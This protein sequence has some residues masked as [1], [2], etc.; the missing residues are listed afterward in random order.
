MLA[1]GCAPGTGPVEPPAHAPAET[2]KTGTGS[3]IQDQGAPPPE[4]VPAWP[5]QVRKTERGFPVNT[6]VPAGHDADVRSLTAPDGVHLP[7]LELGSGERGILLAHERGSGICSWLPLAEELAAKGYHVMLFEY[8]NHG[9]AEESADTAAMNADTSTALA[10]LHRRGA[11]SVLM[12]GASCGGTSTMIT[13]T[14]EPELTGLL[15][16]SSPISCREGD[17]VDAVRTIAKPA[18]FAVSPGDMQGGHQREL[19]KLFAAAGM[20]DKHLEIVPG[21]RHGTDMLNQAEDGGNLRRLILGFVDSA[22]AR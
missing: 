12:G 5:Q 10:E 11:R 16:L 7:A 3:N 6:C 22:F 21:E 20:A 19:E 14:G 4:Y 8:R 1:S 13:A 15:I 18:F 17:A 2:T 9:A